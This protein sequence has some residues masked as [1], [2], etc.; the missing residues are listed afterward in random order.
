MPAAKRG[1]ESRR[2]APCGRSQ[3][4]RQRLMN[5]AVIDFICFLYCLKSALYVAV[6]SDNK[7]FFCNKF[8][9]RFNSY[10]SLCEILLQL[11]PDFIYQKASVNCNSRLLRFFFSPKKLIET[12]LPIMILSRL[13]FYFKKGVQKWQNSTQ[14]T[15]TK[16]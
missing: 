5:K 15:Q 14:P 8:F 10:N 12:L 11:L 13:F 16:P 4:V 1:F 3:G 6:T 9:S 7:N 2:S